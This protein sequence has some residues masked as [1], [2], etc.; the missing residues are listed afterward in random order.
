VDRLLG[1]WDAGAVYHL[2]TV[3]LTGGVRL[4]SAND[5]EVRIWDLTG[6][7]SGAAAVELARSP[8]EYPGVNGVAV[9]RLG[10]DRAVIGVATEDGVSWWDPATGREPFPGAEVGP[11]WDVAAASTPDGRVR[12]FGAAYSKPWPVLCWDAATGQELPP[13]G[14]HDIS[15]TAVVAVALPDHLLVASADEAG[16]VRCWDGS[17]ASHWPNRSDGVL[18]GHEDR[19]RAMAM[20]DL[21]G[22]RLLLA[23]ADMDGTINRW[24]P[25][26]GDLLGTSSGDDGVAIYQLHVTLLAGSPQLI[27]V[28]ADDVIRRWDAITGGLIDESLTGWSATTSVVDG[29]PALVVGDA[30]GTTIN[31]YE[32]T[33]LQ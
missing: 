32:L 18:D 24:D 6:T 25:V 5:S 15:I 33:G 22:G 7:T 20:A 9:G 12:L 31:L 14:Y 28:G 23:T 10:R 4:V 17:T 19:V 3:S 8:G 27:S 29:R 11:I 26:T 30:D 16:T 2:T 13:I 1:R 21:G